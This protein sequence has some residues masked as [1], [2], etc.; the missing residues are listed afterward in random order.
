MVGVGGIRRAASQQQ[1]TVAQAE[2]D[3]IL[4]VDKQKL[5]HYLRYR[6][7]AFLIPRFGRWWPRT[8]LETME[9]RLEQGTLYVSQG[10][11]F[12]SRKAIP[13]ERITDVAL[14]QGPVLRKYFDL[15]HLCIQTAG[16]NSAWPEAVLKGLADPQGARDAILT[17]AKG[18][19]SR[20][21][22][23]PADDDGAA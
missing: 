22:D 11:F 5:L 12:R 2:G 13:V 6:T 14:Y 16:S 4:E 1:V 3:M 8:Y 17:A 20:Q 19:G 9:Y 15:W 23:V 10:V 7:L 21:P 18:Q